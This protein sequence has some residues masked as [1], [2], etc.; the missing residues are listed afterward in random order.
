M[1]ITLQAK[2]HAR[3]NKKTLVGLSMR[4]PNDFPLLTAD[5]NISGIFKEQSFSET[6]LVI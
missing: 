2:G 5:F 6:T 1:Y 4:S 3:N